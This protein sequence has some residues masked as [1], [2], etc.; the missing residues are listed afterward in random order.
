MGGAGGRVFFG[1][2]ELLADGPAELDGEASFG[3]SGGAV[4]TTPSVED[5]GLSVMPKCINAK[6]SVMTKSSAQTVI[7][8]KDSTI[9]S[10]E[11]L[12]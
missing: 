3:G 12:L 7:V 5:S 9:V 2:P 10:A 11:E 1:K 4:R 6:G 8:T